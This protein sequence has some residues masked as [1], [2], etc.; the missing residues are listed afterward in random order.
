MRLASR[1]DRIGEI[2]DA[3]SAQDRA[4]SCGRAR[5]FAQRLENSLAR[6]PLLSK[7]ASLGHVGELCLGLEAIALATSGCSPTDTS[8]SG[9]FGRGERYRSE[10]GLLPLSDL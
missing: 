6:L 5:R 7:R 4:R 9:C 2:A 10:G 3:A 8:I 1:C